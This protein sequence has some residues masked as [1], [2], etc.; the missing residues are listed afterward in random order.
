[1]FLLRFSDEV[2]WE[3]C[4]CF[5]R[6]WQK[7]MF[8]LRSSDLCYSTVISSFLFCTVICPRLTMDGTPEADASRNQSKHHRGDLAVKR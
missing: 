2:N 1:M 4:E 7:N 6:L 3:V 5:N 8:A